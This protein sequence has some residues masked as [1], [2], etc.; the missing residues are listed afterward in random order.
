[1]CASH[2]PAG[3]KMRARGSAEKSIQTSIQT[4]YSTVQ[5]PVNTREKPKFLTQVV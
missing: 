2:R 3:G 4:D 1:M 5:T